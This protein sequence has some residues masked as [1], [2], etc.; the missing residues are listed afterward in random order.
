MDGSIRQILDPRVLA[1]SYQQTSVSDSTP[2]AD[3]FWA[4]QYESIEDDSYRSMYDPSDLKAM[5]SNVP[6]GEARVVTVGAAQERVFN[7]FYTYNVMPVKGNILQALREPDSYSIQDKGRSELN[8]L[9]R[10]FKSR[11]RRFKD[12][13]LRN[14]LVKGTCYFDAAGN[15]LESSSGAV[16][17]VNSDVPSGNQGTVGG[18]VSALWSVAGTNLFKQLDDIRDYAASQL[19]PV[20]TDIWMNAVNFGYLRDNTGSNLANYF[21]R[22]VDL[23]N[24]VMRKN[25]AGAAVEQTVTDINGF[26]WHFLTTYYQDK[27]GTAR[28]HIPKTGA[29]SVIM[30]PSPA[31]DWLAHANGNELVPTSLEPVGTLEEGLANLVYQQGEFFYVKAEHNPVRLDLY[32]GDKFFFG[33]NQPGAIF[34][35]TAF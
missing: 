2:F 32:T 19:V 21:Q 8:R 5:P 31:G 18:L 15:I 12:L 14:M 22:N 26:T 9:L 25:T 1:N 11:T 29:G 20:P 28:P 4:G 17:T 16:V 34:Q 33:F 30:T 24:L 3:T 10:K 23:N 7:S 35:L 13:V 27:D 6:G